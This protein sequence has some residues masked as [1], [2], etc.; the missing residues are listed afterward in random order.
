MPELPEVETVRLGLEPFMTGKKVHKITTH[1]EGLRVPFPKGLAALQGRRIDKLTRRAK[2]L[3]VHMGSDILVIHLGMSG[4]ITAMAD[5]KKY[6]R[7][8][9][10][11]F[12]LNLEGDS[13]IVFNDPRRFGIVL[14]LAEKD[15]EQNEAFK[16]LGP[17]P[18]SKEFT[19]K[20][21]QSRLK[22]KKVPIK[23]ALLDQRVVA[24]IGNIYDC[25]ALFGAG[26]APQRLAGD[27]SA[28]E[29]DVLVKCIKDVLAKAIKAGGSSLKD[30][31]K[32]DGELGYFQY[33]FKV[34]DREGEACSRCATVI[35]KA[36]LI[37][38]I[39]QGARSTFFCARCQK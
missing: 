29:C 3:L 10:D 20:V 36:P 24:G 28:K 35:K 4:R 18:L 22:G 19:G 23:I 39:T 16:S 15:L 21:L 5:L 17:E 13:G 14:M 11:H 1:R 26:I 32:A 2:Y 6:K 27:L 38:R 33:G 25:E 8:K 37:Q 9:H 31:R 12:I 34:Y 7:A 30:Y